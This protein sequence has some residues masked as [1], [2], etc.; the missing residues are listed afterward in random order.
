[1]IPQKTRKAGKQKMANT[2]ISVKQIA[3]ETLP[4]LID[5]LV[6]PN[7]IYRDTAAGG[8]AKKG[9]TVSVR[10]PVKLTAKTFSPTTGVTS[11]G[12]T[13]E[14]VNVKLD[15]IA[16]VD[17][18]ISAL[19]GALDFDSVTRLFIEPAAA[20]L[21]EKINS[22]GLSLYRDIPYIAGTAGT[23]PSQLSDFADAAFML[24]TNRVPTSGRRAVWSPAAS[25]KFKQIPSLVN[26]EKCG[27]TTA[28]RSGS[29]GEVFGISNYMT[30]AV[31]DHKAGTLAATSGNIAVDA[32]VENKS[33]VT[34]A[35]T[36][37]SGTLVRGDI[38]KIG[39][40]TYTVTADAAAA[41]GKITA[42]VY[43]NV[44]AAKDEAVTAVGSHSANL[45]FHPSA[46]AF[47]TRPLSTPAGV[48]SYVTTYN[49]ISLRV[50]RGYDMKYKREM[51]SMDVL[52]SFATLYPELACRYLG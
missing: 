30:Q 19:E 41:S 40:N 6:F 32:A 38:L 42:N 16:T 20:A 50:V 43:P 23:T 4:R 36:G 46:F 14:A 12:I 47:V 35:G 26:A 9:D 17:T 2:F 48:E 51:L 7:L 22:D 5:N 11:Q 21:A 15:N 8:S 28:L 37:L 10:R 18:E 29:I 24:D 33:A 25:A 49:G 34:L 31:C 13:E 3:R 44:T 39:N 27:D 52:Y 1:M 45:V